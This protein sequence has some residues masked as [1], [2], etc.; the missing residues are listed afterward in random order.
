MSDRTG[1]MLLERT[2]SYMVGVPIFVEECVHMNSVFLLHTCVVSCVHACVC[3]YSRSVYFSD[4]C[5][6][7]CTCI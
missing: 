5:T 7:V 1:E 3:T 6:F 4:I 2:V